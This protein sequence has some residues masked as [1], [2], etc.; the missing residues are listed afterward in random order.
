MKLKF[1]IL[2]LLIVNFESLFSE[3]K[4]IILDNSQNNYKCI[5]SVLI[6]ENHSKTILK[7][8][9]NP[10]LQLFRQKQKKNKKLVAAALAFPFPFGIVGLHRIYL[11]TAPYIPV[12]YI[13]T[14]GGGLGI[15]PFIDFCILILDKDFEQYN[16]N[17][18]VFMWLKSEL[19]E[20]K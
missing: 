10:I 8:R 3:N 11:G 20:T 7:S 13:G 15:L 12:V 9:P 14:I 2:L 18:K 1:S 17:N 16:N 6:L 19:K 4:I 5:N